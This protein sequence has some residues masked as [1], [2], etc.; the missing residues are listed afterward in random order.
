MYVCIHRPTRTH[1]GRNTHPCVCVCVCARAR[2]HKDSASI[3]QR[4]I[5]CPKLIKASDNWTSKRE[6]TPDERSRQE[7]R[8][9]TFIQNKGRT[10]RHSEAQGR[11]QINGGAGLGLL[12]VGAG[13]R[14]HRGAFIWTMLTWRGKAQELDSQSWQQVRN[15]RRQWLLIDGMRLSRSWEKCWLADSEIS[16]LIT[17]WHL[18]E[19][20]TPSLGKRVLG[21]L[22]TLHQRFPIRPNPATPRSAYGGEQEDMRVCMCGI[23]TYTWVDIR[24][25]RMIELSVCVPTPVSIQVRVQTHTHTH[26][27]RQVLETLL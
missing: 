9:D 22:R 6:T 7:A 10:D 15:I 13:S 27:M 26:S 8:T 23:D 20:E 17:T 14:K 2:A 1:T 25:N 16:E 19:R 3:W 24:T 12:G 5:R 11:K 4:G 21:S 18:T